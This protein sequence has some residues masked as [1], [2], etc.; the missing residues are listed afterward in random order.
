MRLGVPSPT[1]MNHP[2]K[3]RF[4]QSGPAGHV[5]VIIHLAWHDY[6]IRT[7]TEV[8]PGRFTDTTTLLDIL[9]SEPQIRARVGLRASTIL[10]EHSPPHRIVFGVLW[11]AQVASSRKIHWRGRFNITNF[12]NIRA[13]G[14]ELLFTI[15]CCMSLFESV[16]GAGG[17]KI[18][19]QEF[20]LNDLVRNSR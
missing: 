5:I 3:R 8:S 20:F 19:R 17:G 11:T 6:V 14:E 7:R 2:K 1:P 9:D 16:L 12:N 13:S 15:Y 4:D 18:K 10:S